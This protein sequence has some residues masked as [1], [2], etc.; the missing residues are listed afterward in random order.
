MKKGFT[1]IETLV[2][3]TILMIAISGPLTVAF[4]GL[5]AADQARNQMTATLLAQDA[6]E[7]I[8]NIKDNNI[9]AGS[10]SGW[11]SAP[12]GADL[13]DCVP[14]NMCAV[15]VTNNVIAPACPDFNSSNC[16]VVLNNT[17]FRRF[18]YL[19]DLTGVSAQV[20]VDVV[21]ETGSYGSASTTLRMDMYNVIKDR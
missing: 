8:H 3:I 7:Y 19:K 4:Q 21:W 12:L 18:L 17:S 10:P 11:L 16:S 5:A 6:M 9:A 2:A 15:D 20:V 1:I 13:R 14:E